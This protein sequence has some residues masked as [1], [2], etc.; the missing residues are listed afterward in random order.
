MVLSIRKEGLFTSLQDLGRF[1]RQRFGIPPR[2]AMD[3]AAARI[4]NLLVGNDESQPVLEFHFP[5]PEIVFEGEGDS[6]P[7]AAVELVRA[8]VRTAE[9]RKSVHMTTI[10]KRTEMH[11]SGGRLIAGVVGG[12]V[13]A[14]DVVGVAAAHDVPWRF[15]ITD[16]PTVSPYRRHVPRHRRPA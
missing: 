10:R 1:G 4:V 9:L 6:P 13:G 8:F 15:W 3:R 5:G 7:A 2:G 11:D 16:D 12:R 14:H